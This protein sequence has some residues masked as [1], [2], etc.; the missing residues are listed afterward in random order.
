[1]KIEGIVSALGEQP[2][3]DDS[4]CGYR[5]GGGIVVAADIVMGPDAALLRASGGG[6]G[7][8]LGQVGDQTWGWSG[9]GGGGGRIK[10]YAPDNQWTGKTEV[11]GGLG[12]K[13]PNTGQS[14]GGDPG[15]AGTTFVADTLPAIHDNLS[16]K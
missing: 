4:Q 11:A 1:M 5:P 14:F 15:A 6:G 9:G 8:A 10:V 7:E 16:C 3:P 2:P 13:F 12:G